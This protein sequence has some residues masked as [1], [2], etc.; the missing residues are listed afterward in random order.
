MN[1][2]STTYHDRLQ[3]ELVAASRRLHAQHQGARA[4]GDA[5]RGPRLRVRFALGSTLGIAAVAGIAALVIVLGAGTQRA[6]AEWSRWTAAPT[7]PAEGQT[8]AAEQACLATTAVADGPPAGPFRHGAL[9]EAQ[10]GPWRVLVADTR[11]PFTLV[12]LQ[13]S[14][15]NAIASC[16]AGSSGVYGAG[17]YGGFPGGKPPAVPAEEIQIEGS[18]ASS[19]GPS[20]PSEPG[21]PYSYVSGEVGSGVSAVTLVLRDGQRVTPTVANGWLLAWWPTREPAVAAEVTTPHGTTTQQI[22][23]PAE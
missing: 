23:N 13:S 5:R 22:Y 17:E 16:L 8:A 19:T 6:S 4:P 20:T 2:P 18:G 1:E 21:H 12:L 11:G 10:S 15:L 9:A 14:N 3:R 7:T